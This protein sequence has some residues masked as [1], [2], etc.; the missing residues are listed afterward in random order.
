MSRDYIT[1]PINTLGNY[2]IPWTGVWTGI[3]GQQTIYNTTTTDQ[4]SYGS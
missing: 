3:L 4:Y 2:L 1:N